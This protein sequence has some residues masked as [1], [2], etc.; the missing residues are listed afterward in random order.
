MN[1]KHALQFLKENQP[2]PSDENL[3]DEIIGK[4][5]EIKQYFFGNPDKRCIE[6]FLNSFGYIDGWGVYQLVD[7]VILQFPSSEVIPYLLKAL[8][9]N[10]PSIKYW[11]A[12][13]SANYPCLQLVSALE[14]LLYDTDIDIRSASLTGLCRCKYTETV[15]VLKEYLQYE[16]DEDLSEEAKRILVKLE[17]IL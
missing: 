5:D 10:Y 7:S 13:I 16:T 6:L 3:T 11:N 12:Q 4:Y 17:S 8:K 2:M 15:E 14:P 9:S 1:T